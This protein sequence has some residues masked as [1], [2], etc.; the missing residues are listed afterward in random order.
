MAALRYHLIAK[1]D[2]DDAG[3]P[4]VMDL[5]RYDGATVEEPCPKGYYLIAT[6]SAAG[7]TRRRW[8]AHGV[9]VACCNLFDPTDAADWARLV[10]QKGSEIP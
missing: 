6:R 8:E 4:V 1:D 3:V 10:A 9:S 2:A 7:L 5:L